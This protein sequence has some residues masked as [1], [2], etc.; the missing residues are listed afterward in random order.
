MEMIREGNEKV[1]MELSA[2]T[3]GRKNC[4]I[5]ILL[6]CKQGCEFSD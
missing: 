1:K 6:L 5:S 4:E 2:I 3:G